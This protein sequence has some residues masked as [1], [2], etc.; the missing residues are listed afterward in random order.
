M[1]IKTAQQEAVNRG[2]KMGI[3]EQKPLE[4]V[5]AITEELGEVV[6][7]VALFEQVGNKVN[8]KRKADK[9]LLAREISQLLINV[10]SLASHYDI[11]MDESFR[12]LLESSTSE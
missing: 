12:D 2:K 10:M 7:E 4:I 1:E 9:Q 11:D 5:A 3:V 8:W 6:T